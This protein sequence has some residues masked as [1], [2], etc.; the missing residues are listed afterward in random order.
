[1]TNRRFRGASLQVAFC[2]VG[3][4]RKPFKHY[5]AIIPDVPIVLLRA[6]G[7]EVAP[8]FRNLLINASPSGSR[9][10]RSS[11]YQ[12]RLQCSRLK[13]GEL[14]VKRIKKGREDIAASLPASGGPISCP[15]SLEPIKIR[16][17][18][19]KFDAHPMERRTQRKQSTPRL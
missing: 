11:A 15:I 17:W 6:R 10:G 2:Y 19:I 18:R 4:L 1:M 16:K 8:E 7:L 9:P 5:H 14:I 3:H 13:L 12:M